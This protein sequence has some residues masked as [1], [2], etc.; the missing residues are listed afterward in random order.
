VYSV[1]Y[2]NKALREFQKLDK[3]TAVMIFGWIDKNLVNCSNPRLHGEALIGDKKGYWR[4][5]IGTYRLIADIHDD[6]V[7]IEII[8][9]AHRRDIYN[10][11]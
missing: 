2:S 6:I 7:A 8:N 4:Y 1:V 9:V 11:R 10:N 3:P 5:R